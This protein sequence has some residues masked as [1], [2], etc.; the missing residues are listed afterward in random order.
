MN[1][2]TA[3]IGCS[4]SSD[5]PTLRAVATMNSTMDE[6]KAVQT[7]V[8][9]EDDLELAELTK[10]RLERE[11]FSVRHEE[12]GEAGRDAIVGSQPDLVVLDIMLPGIDGFEV[13]K[14]VRPDYAGPILILTARD[15]DLDE[16]LGLEL[17]ADDF[18]TKPVKPRLLLARIRA[19]LRRAR[20][21]P[22]ARVQEKVSIGSLVVDASRRETHV[23]DAE[24]ELTT[25][26][27]DL[28]WY[29][30]THAGE[31]VSRQDIYQ[32][33]FQYDYDGLDR[34]VD[35]YISRLRHRL[36][37]QPTFPHYI[38]TVR[39]VGYLMAGEKT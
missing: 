36:G 3:P 20:L 31:V 6:R 18:V 37:D 8:L 4:D 15:E 38:K 11:G 7:I 21:E 19:L 32:A 29:L 1:A 12:N 30:A 14:Q 27:F 39:G 26:E 33:L 28:L 17:G 10:E 13:C 5:G 34:S 9:V 2:S 35:V 23:D 25:T 16:I 22:S 24:V